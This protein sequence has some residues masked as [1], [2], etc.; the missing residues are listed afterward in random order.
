MC[1][2]NRSHCPELKMSQSQPYVLFVEDDADVRKTAELLL[3]KH[4]Y[5]FCGAASPEEAMSRLVSE[6]IDLI[7][8]DL[9]FSKGQTTGEEGLKCL[10]DIRRHD[11]DVII[12]VV[13]GHSGIS[14]AVQAL[15]SGATDFIMKPWNNDRLVEAI[16]GA[17]AARKSRDA[18]IV[19]P[20]VMVGSS[21]AVV[22]IRMAIDRCAPLAVPV[23]LTGEAGTGKTLAAMAFHRQ[24]GRQTMTTVEASALTQSHLDDK[25]DKTLVIENIDR[26]D[27][28]FFPDLLAWVHRAPKTNSRLITT[29]TKNR[30]QIGLDRGLIYA[31]STLDIVLPPLSERPDDLVPLA[32]HFVRVACQQYEFPEKALSTEAKALLTAQTWADNI[33]ELRHVIERAVVLVPSS[34]I[35]GTDVATQSD[36]G[37]LFEPSKLRLADSEKGIIEDALK[38]N[39][40]NVSAAATDLGLTRPALYR[41][42]AKHGL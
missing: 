28:A 13:T 34:V 14:V 40:F 36:G 18:I 27:P 10:R 8:L 29:S 33:H 3:K 42:M 11:P 23:L 4:G 17:L 2:G 21:E 22:R 20:S 31:I 38:R 35:S 15:R 25:P 5:T 41:R 30:A 39:N 26:L 24:S 12:I 19:D 9:N 32:E 7:L 6:S 37:T 16:D 1:P